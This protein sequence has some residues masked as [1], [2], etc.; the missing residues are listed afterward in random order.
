LRQINKSIYQYL[1][2]LEI[3][4]SL[5]L[6]IHCAQYEKSNPYQNIAF[7]YKIGKMNSN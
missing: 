3:N 6:S 2:F 1:G 4:I 5:M 7:T